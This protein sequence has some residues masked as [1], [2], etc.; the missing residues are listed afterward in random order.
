V[1]LSTLVDCGSDGSNRAAEIRTAP[2][3]VDHW[4]V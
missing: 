4:S 2:L 1:K 3:K